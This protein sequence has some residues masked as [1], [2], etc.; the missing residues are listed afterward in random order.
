MLGIKEALLYGFYKRTPT[1]WIIYTKAWS[2]IID[3]S[4]FAEFLWINFSSIIYI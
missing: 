2:Y 3:K 1:A 4:G